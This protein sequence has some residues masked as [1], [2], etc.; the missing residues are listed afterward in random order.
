MKNPRDIWRGGWIGNLDRNLDLL[1]A[2]ASFQLRRSHA[3]DKPGLPAGQP[4]Y[5]DSGG[6]GWEHL[7]FAVEFYH[8]DVLP[9]NVLKHQ[10]YGLQISLT[11]AQISHGD[12]VK[13]Q[14]KHPWLKRND[15]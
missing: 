6:K 2:F 3:F 5:L 11:T 8:K 4:G 14:K 7:S 9:V 13:G 12:K 10:S 1:D 15:S